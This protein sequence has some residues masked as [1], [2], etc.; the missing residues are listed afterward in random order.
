MP[1]H[2]RQRSGCHPNSSRGRRL[3]RNLT[4]ENLE[5]RQML[6]ADLLYT[7]RARPGVPDSL[8]G[9]A[10]D[11]S[12]Q[13]QVIGNPAEPAYGEPL[14]S[15]RG[16]VQI[17]DAI[18]GNRLR[19]IANPEPALGFSF[20]TSI[21]IDQNFI[22]VGASGVDEREF[23]QTFPFPD[24]SGRAYLFDANTGDLIHTFQPD[25][26]AVIDFEHRENLDGFGI[27]LDIEGNYIVIGAPG[28]PP[29]EELDTN[30]YDDGH[31][32]VFNRTTGNLIRRIDSP[33]SFFIGG[34]SIGFGSEVSLSQGRVVINGSLNLA[35]PDFS[36]GQAHVYDV[37]AGGPPL[38]TIAPSSPNRGFGG[39]LSLH[40]DVLAVGSSQFVNGVFEPET[41]IYDADD[42]SLSSQILVSSI[43]SDGILLASVSAPS[44]LSRLYNIATGNLI[45]EIGIPASMN[46]AISYD[47]F[48][49]I[50]HW[51]IQIHDQRVLVSVAADGVG[52]HPGVYV[53]SLSGPANQPPTDI[54]LTNNT[55]PENSTN[56]TLIGTFSATDPTPDETFTFSLLNSAGGRFSVVANE[57]RVGNGNL[58]DFDTTTSH[59]IT[60]RVTDSAGNTF[61]EVL[62]VL[63][64]NVN[65]P[66]TDI[67][68]TPPSVVENAANSTIVGN[69]A[70]N[71]PD[72]PDPQNFALLD[73][74]GGRF[75]LVGDQLVVANGAAID[76]E[77]AT[78]H[79]VTVQV[80]DASGLSLTK[81]LNINVI[82]ANDPISDILLSSNTIT[83]SKVRL[84]HNQSTDGTLLGSELVAAGDYILASEQFGVFPTVD[85]RV[86]LI[87][88]PSGDLVRTFQ[89]PVVN[90]TASDPDGGFG[91]SLAV[92]GSRAFIGA[93]QTKVGNID[94]A[95]AV[96][97]YNLANG[98]LLLTLN[99]PTPTANGLFGSSIATSGN[100]VAI[101]S[102]NESTGNVFL[103]N[104]TTGQL[105][106]TIVNPTPGALEAFGQSIA[107]SGNTLVAGS[108]FDDAG[109]V[110]AG[111]AYIFEFNPVTLTAT[112]SHTLTNPNLFSLKNFGSTVAIS[113]NLVAVKDSA[114][115]G[116]L[117][118]VGT[119]HLFDR[120]S[121][122]FLRTLSNPAPGATDQFGSALGI[123]GDF[124]VA[125]SFS[126]IGGFNNGR[127]YVFQASTGILIA[128]I[129][130]P[131]PASSDEFAAQVAV[132]GSRIILSSRGD[133]TDGANRGMIYAFELSI[134]QAVGTLTPIGPV[135]G[136]PTTYSL[137]D[138]A[139]GIFAIIGDQLV[140]ADGTKIDYETAT[141]H[142]VTVTATSS[143][144]SS[145]TKDFAI[146]VTNVN[147]APSDLTFVGNSV[148]EIA[149]SGTLV[150]T[151]SAI[152]PD[153][154]SSF[155][156]TLVDN[157]G[158]RFAVSGNTIVVANSSLIDYETN[159]LHVLK[160]RVTD[161]GGVSTL[162]SFVINVIDVIEVF[163][164]G[165]LPASFG[166]LLV[167]NGPRHGI[168]P[169]GPRLGAAISIESNGQPSA[170][171]TADTF[172]DGVIFP[173][174]LIPGLNAVFSVD[175]SQAGK[176]DAFI[177]FGGNGNFSESERITPVGGLQL[178]AG[179]NTFTAAI[180][181]TAGSG[182]RGVRFRFS[183]AGGLGPKGIAA[184]GEVE[185]YRIDVFA[186]A[187]LSSQVLPDPENPGQLLMY[188]RGSAL[189]D[190]IAINPVG[191]GLR[192][193]INGVQGALLAAPGRIVMFG[194]Q[195]NDDMRINA[196]T[197]PSY[198][199]G[200]L[201]HDTIR[202]GNGP[203]R[204]FGRS[205]NDII[206]GRGG[207]DLIYG[208][209]GNDQLYSGTEAGILF[210][211][212]NDDLLV[213][214]GILVGG[215]GVDALTATTSRNLLI[216]GKGGDTLTGA[217]TNQGDILIAGTTSYD[218]NVDA[219]YSLLEEWQVDA[220]VLNR[221][222]H[223]NGS[224]LGGLNGSYRLNDSTVFDD[225]EADTIT[226][227]GTINPQRDDWVF[228]SANDTKVNPPGIVVVVVGGPPGGE[229]ATLS[230]S[231]GI[232]TNYSTPADVNF[233]GDNPPASSSLRRTKPRVSSAVIS[234]SENQ[235]R[236]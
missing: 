14:G 157:A 58:L 29:S 83:E 41:R 65:E 223:L 49:P 28:I 172:D 188:V 25:P 20:G 11:A 73:N 140:V 47:P 3:A 119:V 226:N 144:G 130:N 113:G 219:L 162:E 71:D 46:P 69:L 187:N 21:A 193:I 23:D 225:S 230:Q 178:V 151:L 22:L 80:T 72:S 160:V 57:L 177:D 149:A 127:V 214:T 112:L 87:H 24:L 163:D 174:L 147:E 95:G 103:F 176:L 194:L 115:V 207:V 165:D 134:G 55:I 63:L 30:D 51:P 202:G 179:V 78:S 133:D 101:S 138:D 132:S 34:S 122:N 216:G 131:S 212:G 108:R 39:F 114:S 167:G 213:G 185:D 8:F 18:T 9:L 84:V 197:I 33:D 227:F 148:S 156:Y 62:Q 109:G 141:S 94:G 54:A 19:T 7:L 222:A 152:D 139:N 196:T 135:A 142:S 91:G 204:I 66:P 48:L 10:S 171:A 36:T 98:S 56:S 200:G 82:D 88:A 40:G 220:P 143:D 102:I 125:N 150:T 38:Q 37:V 232:Y 106:T 43:E 75:T 234:R 4:I 45:N 166:T 5:G 208:S 70:S 159:T 61:N 111:V 107:I 13:F 182:N 158:G 206:F 124:I 42:G 35:P 60:V 205:G 85:K 170:G 121:G 186:P 190:D 169:G 116:A 236:T 1:A 209:T 201:G 76:F 12:D 154:G 81:S 191:M 67:A 231:L 199:D 118:N 104:A 120:V 123:F 175:A 153:V 203:D 44:Y 27:S 168:F 211:E 235:S 64:T 92:S 97:V 224:V 228:L 173:A 74:A 215:D 96:Y 229:A 53:F 181:T 221:I 195:G 217:N 31:V 86:Q 161:A 59:T 129:V 183:T 32:Y 50:V 93:N 100:I 2:C 99:S 126:D 79:S 15:Y 68:L 137:L 145:F 110:D 218:T 16:E 184:D 155:S 52:D 233:D 105:L 180:P 6:A 136:D 146:S 17:H 210:G 26:D 189:N 90:P 89:A 164:F 192:A 128:T 77:T 117:T 198:I